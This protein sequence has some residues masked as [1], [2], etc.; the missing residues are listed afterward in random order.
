MTTKK[1]LQTGTSRGQRIAIW[2]IL[3]LT[4]VST[5]ALYV[6]SLLANKNETA[7]AKVQQDK[8]AKY[9]KAYKEYQAKVKTQA[10][11]LS[12]KY[13]DSFKEYEKY[14]SA[15]NASSVKEL[16][17]NDLRIGEGE[18]IS[19]EY[20]AYYIGWKPDGTVFDGSFEKG[21]LKAPL[22]VSSNN[23]MIKGWSEGVKGMKVGGIRELIIPSYK[24][25]GATGKNDQTDKA[26]SIPANTPLKF[27][28]MIIPK[29]EVKEIELP[30]YTKYLTE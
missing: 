23:Q 15:F 3:I 13:Y 28:V 30:D 8:I 25:Y 14:P 10:K 21:A 4:V 17:T 27:I 9:Q 5:A 16:K 26:K 22:T 29:S 12:A 11:E 24:A 19:Q 1:T 20:A 6:G 18:E 7:D 2:T